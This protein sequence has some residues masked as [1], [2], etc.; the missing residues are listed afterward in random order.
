MFDTL[1]S[2]PVT[3]EAL[4]G[5]VRRGR[6][7][8]LREGESGSDCTHQVLA[9]VLLAALAPPAPGTARPAA[10]A[11]GRLLVQ[12]ARRTRRGA[13]ADTAEEARER[14]RAVREALQSLGPFYIRVGQMLSTRPDSCPRR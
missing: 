12:E 5:E 7:F 8:R 4:A 10:G 9:R 1:T 11:L 6:R 3:L 13:G 2:R 14:A